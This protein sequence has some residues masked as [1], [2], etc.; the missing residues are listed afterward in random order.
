MLEGKAMYSLRDVPV[1]FSS[2][3]Q[4]VIWSDVCRTLL[5]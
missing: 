1:R 3:D 4:A 5:I 2:V